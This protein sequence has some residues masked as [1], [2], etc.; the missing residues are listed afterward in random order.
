MLRAPSWS[1]RDAQQVRIAVK[2]NRK[3][4]MDRRAFLTAVSAAA[5]VPLLAKGDGAALA[6]H[7]GTPVR[8]T[9]LTTHYEGAN[10]IGGAEKTE[11]VETIDS[12]NLFRFLIP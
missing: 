7:G 9:P 12:R 2:T 6:L 11:V 10:F 5:S 3:S 4:E 1:V 8:S